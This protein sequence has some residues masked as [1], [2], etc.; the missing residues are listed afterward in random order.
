MD[1]GTS[2]GAARRTDT[3]EL[4]AWD[5]RLDGTGNARVRSGERPYFPATHD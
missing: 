3:G 1:F 5:L 4:T 2:D